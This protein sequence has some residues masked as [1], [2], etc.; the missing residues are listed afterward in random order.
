MEYKMEYRDTCC[1]CGELLLDDE[2]VLLHDVDRSE[3]FDLDEWV[4]D[5]CAIAKE[6][7]LCIRR[8][9]RNR[10]KKIRYLHRKIARMTAGKEGENGK[11]ESSKMQV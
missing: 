9:E 11:N 1:L 3:R 6:A 10:K 2:G 8:I 4:C 7:E 5:S